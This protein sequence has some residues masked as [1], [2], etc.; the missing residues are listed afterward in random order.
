V[1]PDFDHDSGSYFLQLEVWGE[2]NASDELL[3]ALKG[4]CRCCSSALRSTYRWC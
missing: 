3:W 2:A 4:N 1:L